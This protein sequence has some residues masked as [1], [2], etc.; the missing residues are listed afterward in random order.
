[1]ESARL[2]ELERGLHGVLHLIER[3]ESGDGGQLPAEHPA[4]RAAEACE[5]ML[6]ESLT[7][8]TLAESVRHKIDN[9]QV[10]LERARQH[11]ALPADAQLAAAEDYIGG[12]DELPAGKLPADS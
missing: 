9:V 11:E 12:L 8:A 10:L 1:M 4:A 7:L 5:L 2:E 3:D 6:P